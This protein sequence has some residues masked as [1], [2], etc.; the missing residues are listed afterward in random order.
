MNN[1][2]LSLSPPPSTGQFNIL[3]QRFA[4]IWCYR[5][6]KYAVEHLNLVIFELLILS[7]TWGLI[8]GLYLSYKMGKMKDSSLL[9]WAQNNNKL[10]S[11]GIEYAVN[12]TRQ[13]HLLTFRPRIIFFSIFWWQ[14]FS[15]FWR[16]KFQSFEGKNFN[17]LMAKVSIFWW[18]KFQSF[19]G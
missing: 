17:L 12:R 8:A 11:K 1:V 5:L 3:L 4:I 14:K 6:A 16:Q 19:E 15:I 10:N 2:S 9:K 13:Q 18:Q 7:Y